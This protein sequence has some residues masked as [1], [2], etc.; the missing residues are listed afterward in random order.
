MNPR[1]LRVG[2]RLGF[3]AIG[4][5]GVILSA[6]HR[7]RIQDIEPVKVDIHRDAVDPERLADPQVE[8]LYRLE[9]I[10]PD[11]RYEQHVLQRIRI[12][13]GGLNL[14]VAGLSVPLADQ[15]VGSH[16]DAER[17]FVEPVGHELELRRHEEDIRL[18][19]TARARND[20]PSVS[21]RAGG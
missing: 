14:L 8:T 2:F 7:G 6:E 5:P 9:P 4:R 18:T 3:R 11:I 17:R 13:R 10:V 12:P 1:L 15:Q 16:V 21:L 20:Q 19:A